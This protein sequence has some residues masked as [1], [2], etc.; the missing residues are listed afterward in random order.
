M[1]T[2]LRSITLRLDIR[3]PEELA[4]LNAYDD[5]MSYRK[6]DLLRMLLKTG[7]RTHGGIVP[8]RL[9]MSQKMH[10]AVK[11]K[12]APMMHEPLIAPLKSA[13]LMEISPTAELIK[14]VEAQEHQVITSEKPMFSLFGHQE[15]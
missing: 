13:A 1:M 6:Q 8:M 12:V 9:P 15:I 5:T 11:P 7:L 10:A 4:R 14:E 2:F 3:D